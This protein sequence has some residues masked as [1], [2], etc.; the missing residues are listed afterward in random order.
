MLRSF[1]FIQPKRS[2]SLHLNLL[3]RGSFINECQ[4]RYPGDYD[5][6]SCLAKYYT[7]RSSPPDVFLGKD[8]LK[9][10][11]KFIGEQPS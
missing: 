2:F 8:I 7:L 9:I 11:S 3:K 4:S 1:S 6:R 10:C 5:Q